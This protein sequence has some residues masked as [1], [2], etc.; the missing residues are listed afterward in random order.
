M[1]G[2]AHAASGSSAVSNFCDR[3]QEL[4]ASQQNLVLQFAAVVRDELGATNSSAVLISRSGLDL[5]RFHIRYSHAAIAWQ[6]ENDAWTARQLYY[7]CD[8]K[9]PRIY[10][11]GLAGFAMGID[12]P[13]LGY[14]SIVKLPSGA[15]QAL[16]QTS[17]D[18][19]RALRL[20]AANYSA[21]AYAYGL[22]YQ[23]CNQWVMEMLAAAWGDLADGGDLR[24]RAQ[25]WLRQAGYAPQAV[26][27]DSH[28]LM[29]AG[30]FVPLLH[31]DDHPESDLFAMKLKISLPATVETFV[32][33]R[34]PG[35]ERI[36]ICHDDK[37]VVVHRGWSPIADGC[38][39]GEG[40]RVVYLDG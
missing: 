16:R 4:S 5:S 21:N 26:D 17:L 28:W 1:A 35:S 23:N 11:Q 12:N 8:E 18:S 29:F 20:L 27:V 30:S 3:T 15:A 36:E 6:D 25:R 34:L 22:L 32:Q 24:E 31:L 2:A 38:V 37:R 39:P 33:Q 10:D 19:T 7:A 14:I 9:R 13:A 40:D